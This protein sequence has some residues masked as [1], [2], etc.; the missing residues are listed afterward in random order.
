MVD[1]EDGL[2][3]EVDLLVL[4]VE[5]DLQVHQVEADHLEEAIPPPEE[6]QLEESIEVNLEFHREEVGLALQDQEAQDQEEA[7]QLHVTNVVVCQEQMRPREKLKANVLKN[8]TKELE[9][10]LKQDLVDLDLVVPQEDLTVE[11][12]EPAQV[13]VHL[14]L[15][16]PNSI[17]KL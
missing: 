7:H 3:L 14:L 2:L 4:Q 9:L 6:L 8:K 15:Q 12:E 16:Q 11:L 13:Q 17:K 10:I 1:L 5:A